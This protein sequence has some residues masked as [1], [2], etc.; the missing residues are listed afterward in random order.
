[1]IEFLLSLVAGGATGLFGSLVKGV[2]DYFK[3]QQEM[4]HERELRRLDM[5]MMDK[6]WEYRDR[7]ASRE[8]EV[9]VTESG[10]DLQEASYALD[11][12]TYSR[13]FTVSHFV[14]KFLLVSV[15]VVRGLTRPALTVFM[16]WMV[17]NT[18][19][20][21]EDVIARAGLERLDISLA[22]DLE[23]RI[24]CTILYLAGLSVAWW[25][26]DRGRKVGK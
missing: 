21:V 14:N 3:R 16:L 18:R 5:E 22:M 7:A 24:V 23:K 26:G 19:C 25:F 17:W 11:K 4:K 9:R 13:G 1:M 20:Q 12:A 15:D 6:E 2:G 10:D 8:G